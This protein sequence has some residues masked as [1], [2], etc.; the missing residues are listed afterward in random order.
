LPWGEAEL[1]F[2]SCTSAELSYRT[3]SGEYEGAF[4]M[5]RIT[6]NV[7]CTDEENDHE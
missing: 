1:L 2:T 7:Y 3:E 5:Q 6:P 4:E